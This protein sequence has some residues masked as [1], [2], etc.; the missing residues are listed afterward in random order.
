MIY[1]SL[2]VLGRTPGIGRAELESLYGAGHFVPAG[3]F[4]MLSDLPVA[5]VDFR[6][7][8]GTVK[9][10]RV[11]GTLAGGATNAGTGSGARSSSSPQPH[12]RAVQNELSKHAV[13][14][15]QDVSEGKIQLG[16]SVYGV[17]AN[18]RQ[19]LAAGLEIK[20]ALRGHG[21]SVRLVPNQ[22]TALSSAQVLH[23][24]LTGER[25]IELI[26]VQHGSEVVMG[27][28]VAVQD[29][30]AYA[31]RD[32]NRPK[33]DAFVGMLPPKL[34][35][36]IVN[37]GTGALPAGPGH[38]VLDPF[39]GTGVILQEAALTGYGM[40]GTDLET[41]MVDYSEK[42][43]AWLAE[44]AAPHHL[45]SPTL[46]VGDATTHRWDSPFSVIASETYL[47]RPLSSWPGADKLHDIT[48]TC[49]V[50][51]EK[52]LRNLAAQTKPGLRL[53]LAVPAWRAPDG[54]IHH[55][56]LLDHLG[57]MGYNR[58]SF[59]HAGGADLVYFRPDQLVARELLVITRN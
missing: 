37:L 38:V 31:A 14:L 8:G 22:E 48:G 40:Y 28:A 16:V 36:T 59:E 23:N 58:I 12:W 53:C 56:P 3:D 32:Q 5:D 57:E 42:N 43:L 2:F 24:H 10:A 55:L 1:K 46:E 21:Y 47:G 19:L 20:K 4:A 11:V 41:R 51:I 27:R 34:A 52:F 17:S 9:L 15:A 7:L 50:I 25:G 6:R 33:R 29:I 54:R 30:T 26:A 13:A 39:C 49:N 18:P 44:R 45:A 35:Q